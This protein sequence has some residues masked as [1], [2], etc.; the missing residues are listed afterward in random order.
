MVQLDFPQPVQQTVEKQHI[1][2]GS[3]QQRWFL[4]IF[5]NFVYGRVQD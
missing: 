2:S 1:P 3:K 5:I 4:S